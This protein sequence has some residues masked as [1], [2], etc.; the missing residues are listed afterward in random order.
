[1]C[2]CSSSIEIAIHF[3]LHCANF[4]TQRQILFDKIATVDANILTENKDS[5]VDPLLFE[6]PNNENPCNKAM[7]N[8]SI[9]F[10]LSTERFKDIINLCSCLLKSTNFSVKRTND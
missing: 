9:K 7:L 4:N 8:A 1:M 5:V 2:N 3:F 6:K 10:I